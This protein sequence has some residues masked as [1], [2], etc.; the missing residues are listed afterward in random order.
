MTDELPTFEGASVADSKVRITKAGDGLSESL[1][2]EPLA[3]HM[4]TEASFCIRG[5][6]SQIAHKTVKGKVIR[7]HTIEVTEIAVMDDVEATDILDAYH[8]H[9]GELRDAKSGQQRIEGD[10]PIHNVAP[11]GTVVT[12]ADAFPGPGTLADPIDDAFGHF[13][14]TVLPD[15]EPALDAAG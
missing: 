13:D 8:E 9:I 7:I 14:P 12:P 6:V 15:V 2:L 1:A 5:T 10:V 11:D 4:G 3:L